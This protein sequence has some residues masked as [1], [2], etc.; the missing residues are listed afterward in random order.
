MYLDELGL[1]ALCWINFS[2]WQLRILKLKNL[3]SLPVMFTRTLKRRTG[4][5]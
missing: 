1:T 3:P 5:I 2:L 4:L